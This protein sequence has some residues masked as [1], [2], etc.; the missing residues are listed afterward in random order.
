[1]YVRREIAIAKIE[2]VDAAKNSEP[3]QQMKCLASKAPTF[4]RIDK[5]RKRVRDDVE[6]RRNLQPVHR[7]VVARV[8]DRNQISRIHHV[9]QT[10]QQLRRTNST[11]ERSNTQLLA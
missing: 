6:V 10:E 5:I 8:D 9:I 1:M 7:D 11:G 2:P 3:L 4:F